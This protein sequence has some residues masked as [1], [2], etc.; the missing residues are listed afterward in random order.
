MLGLLKCEI[1]ENDAPDGVKRDVKLRKQLA[2]YELHVHGQEEP[3]CG[4]PRHAV[5]LKPGAGIPSAA[6][7]AAEEHQ[8]GVAE[9]MKENTDYCT[10]LVPA[11]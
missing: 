3:W 7:D 1:L 2:C 9:F 6:A 11:A 4:V 10:P 8:V 5:K